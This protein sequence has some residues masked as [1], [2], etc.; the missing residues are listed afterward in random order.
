MLKFFKRPL[1]IVLTILILAGIVIYFY[2]FRKPAP[3]PEVVA[4]KWGTVIQEVSVTG[5]VKPAEDVN[6]AFEKGGKVAWVGAKIDD[7]VSAGQILVQLE[8]SELLAQLAENKAN[9][10]TQKAE[11]DELKQGTRLEEIKVYE[12]KVENA[13]TA[14]DDAKTALIDK[15]K[16]AYTKSDDAIRNEVDQLFSNPR[17]ASPTI[18]ILE[19]NKKM[20]IEWER[21]V[22]ESMLLKWQTSLDDLNKES[23]LDSHIKDSKA[24]L[25]Q[26]R[27][28]LD[29]VSL[30]VNALVASASLSQ[31]TIDT[32]RLDISTARTNVNTA[33][34]NLSTAEEDFK[35]SQ[36]ALTLA[37]NELSLKKAG[38]LPEQISSQEA[39]VEQA[40]AKVKNI[41]A[42]L[43]KT[44]LRSPINGVVTKQDAKVGEIAT[45]SNAIV[46]VIS[47]ANFEIE[48]NIPE[49]DIAKVKIGD[50]AKVTLDAYGNDVVFEVRVSNIEP[51]ETLIEGVPTYKTTLQF[52]SRDERV[53]SGMTANVDIMTAKAEN[54]IFVPQ[55]AVIVKNGDKIVQILDKN[56]AIKEIKVETGLRGSDGNM[57]I[58]SGLNE[59]DRIIL[60]TTG[61]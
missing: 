2:F 34:V 56:G 30:S 36:S 26:V 5:R 23:D 40:E 48:A 6:L 33:I 1:V 47:E 59:G 25:E 46:S 54:V 55:R 16:D 15:L 8:N 29:K 57:E 51:A 17:S 43:A 37:E 31:T 10:K 9:V 60:Y 35:T 4:V 24:N 22:I 42:Q 20:E 50:L 49:A 32:Y 53:K 41:E 11:L 28:F 18:K 7:K 21:M 61:K 27:N 39:Q 13:K 45:A 38:S 44:V 19:F 58:V 14:L 52:S 3:L 12:V